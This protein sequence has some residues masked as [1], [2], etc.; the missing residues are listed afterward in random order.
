[1]RV[2]ALS[3][4]YP[5]QSV[6]TC[7]LQAFQIDHELAQ[8]G[9]RIRVVTSPMTTELAG[10]FPEPHVFREL[11]LYEE[12]PT[13]EPAFRRLFQM[14]RYNRQVVER[15]L[16]AF[17]P[18]AIV[19]WSMDRLPVSL[20]QLA[21]ESGIPCLYA[22]YNDWLSGACRKDLW[23]EYWRDGAP[24]QPLVRRL[25]RGLHLEKLVDGKAAF[26]KLD[27]L[28]LKHIYFCSEALKQQTMRSCGLSLEQALVI[29]CA[30]SPGQIRQK[31]SHATKSCRLLFA[32]PLCEEK[33]PMTALRALQELR[34][35]G[36]E[37]FSLDIYGR[38]KT[39]FEGALHAYVRRFQ[40]GGSV[41]FKPATAE[42]AQ[43]NIHQY[44]A[45]VFTSQTAEAFPFV[46][47]Q[48]MAAKVP[49]ISTLE[50]GSAELIRHGENGL[51]FET[52]NYHDLADRITQTGDDPALME[53]LAETAFAEVI[54]HY[55]L[56]RITSRIETLLH[57]AVGTEGPVKEAA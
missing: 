12:K 24:N 25:L 39:E 55:S 15:H 41:S 17:V 33:D 47:L 38:G 30:I 6:D 53:Q 27:D 3:S 7:A 13:A 23:A 35:R 16:Q 48:A 37:R 31:G 56:A 20:L 28:Q 18:E 49:V 10:H 19:I 1:M 8:R 22:I 11:K 9:H 5:P 44:D 57:R 36:D 51:A 54:R 50:G 43:A 32:S 21:E 4:F 2:L 42:Q 46:H 14:V 34:H 40:L 29:P 45:L 26:G 52:G